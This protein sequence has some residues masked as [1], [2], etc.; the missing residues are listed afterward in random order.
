MSSNLDPASAPTYR[1]NPLAHIIDSVSWERQENLGFFP[2]CCM[3]VVFW[4][5]AETL[6][7]L[8]EKGPLY[9]LIRT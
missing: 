2:N 1:G 9:N 8:G 3:A 5:L 6:R 7:T 4:E